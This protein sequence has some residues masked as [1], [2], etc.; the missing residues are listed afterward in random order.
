MTKGM[1]RKCGRRVLE[2]PNKECADGG[3]E[4]RGDDE[5]VDFWDNGEDWGVNEV[6]MGDGAKVGPH[7]LIDD[8]WYSMAGEPADASSH[9]QMELDT[10]TISSFGVRLVA[11]R[12]VS[13]GGNR[14]RQVV[15]P[16]RVDHT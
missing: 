1:N 9:W 12:A 2:G 15:A 14:R 5:A 8:V 10:V 3:G 16:F 11:F 13:V 4:E 7:T 6:F